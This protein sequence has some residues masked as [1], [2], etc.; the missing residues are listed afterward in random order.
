MERINNNAYGLDLPEEYAVS[1]TFNISD[2]IPFA[3]G[4]NTEDEEPT[5][6]RS[7]PLQ[8][9]ED[10]AILLRKGPV[11]KAM[12]KRLQE[13]WARATEED[14]WVLM[15][16][17]IDFSAHGPRLGPL[18]SVNIKISF[19]SFRFVGYHTN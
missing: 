10:D 4:A 11:T 19:S 13:D 3:G 1:T 2:L 9:G 6:L 18:F 7:N 16:L 5:N 14:P 8:G 12:S 15:N 17:R